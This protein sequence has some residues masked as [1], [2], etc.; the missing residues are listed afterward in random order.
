M[1]IRQAEFMKNYTY[2]VHPSSGK[3]VF[4]IVSSKTR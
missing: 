4:V 2:I 3:F 1:I